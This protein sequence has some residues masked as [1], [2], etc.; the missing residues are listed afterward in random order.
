MEQTI[1]KQINARRRAMGL[2]ASKLAIAVGVTE[3]AIRKIESGDSKEPRFSTGVRIA[4]ILKMDP[5]ALIATRTQTLPMGPGHDLGSTMR[6]IR[7]RQSDLRE[8]GV[9]HLMVFGSVARGEASAESDVDVIIQIEPGRSFSLFDLASV[10][11][12]LQREL[13]RHVD[14][15]TDGSLRNTRF[16]ARAR[17]E[18]VIVF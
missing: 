16:E 17:E 8:L 1:G 15:L 13:N 9:E 12:I 4:Q 11:E 6:C 10:T 7:A 14:V 18:A 5:A 3:N 2:S